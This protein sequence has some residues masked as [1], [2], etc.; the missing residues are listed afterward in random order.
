MLFGPRLFQYLG[1]VLTADGIG[2]G[3]DRMKAIVNLPTLKTSKALRSAQGMVVFVR[4]FI[5]DLAG[6]LAPLVALTKTEAVNEV[7]KRWGPEQNKAQANVKLLLT[8]APVQK[9]PDLS[10][11]F[12]MHVDVSEAGAGAS[13]AQHK[14]EDLAIIAYNSDRFND[15]QRY[16]PATL[17][18]CC[19]V[20][21]AIQQCRPCRWG[22]QSVCV[23]DHSAQRYLYSMQDTSHMLT[24]GR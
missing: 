21:R 6:Q 18:G 11:D 13:L 12:V 20:V 1:H 24:R 16:Y 15:S 2:I 3:E 9:F 10:R 5:L 19:A 8:Q 7:A 14:C 17:K 23:T 22:R 4:K